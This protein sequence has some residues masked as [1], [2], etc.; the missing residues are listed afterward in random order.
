MS[1]VLYNTNSTFIQRYQRNSLRQ[2][3]NSSIGKDGTTTAAIASQIDDDPFVSK[4]IKDS[5]EYLQQLC[6]SCLPSS[7]HQRI[8]NL[9]VT[10]DLEIVALVA[11]IYKNFISHWYGV[12]IPT[13]DT[14]F[15][16]EI[17][18]I[19]ERLIS[20][21]REKSNL[22]TKLILLDEF[23]VLLSIHICALRSINTKQTM[24][25]GDIYKQYTKL[26]LYEEDTYPYIITALI[27]QSL[28]NTSLL[29]G[30]F[31]DALF[32]QLLLGRVFDSITEPY[33]VLRG[34]SKLCN[35]IIERNNTK[36]S[37]NT[38]SY[39][40][41]IKAKLSKIRK[42]VT[43]VSSYED[44][45]KDKNYDSL[46]NKYITHTFFVDL[47][48]LE[49]KKPLLYSTLKFIQN[50]CSRSNTINKIFNNTL[51]TLINKKVMNSTTVGSLTRLVRHTLFPNDNFMGPRTV[52]PTGVHF[53]EFK[54]DR[55]EELWQVCTIYKAS[56]VL[57]ITKDD[58]KTFI[59][60]I[61]ISKECNKLLMFRL[62]DCMLAHIIDNNKET[63]EISES[64]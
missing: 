46:M 1:T 35:K 49:I 40:S 62:I 42:M 10:P 64:Q 18:N 20:Y 15:A 54:N 30:T 36:I 41:M 2:N 39:W 12:K 32:N 8:R 43:Y 6:C 56:L 51:D 57:N 23:P 34:I 31:I 37:S 55:I 26:T 13:N 60:S 11:L 50:L 17:Y 21:L 25:S 38:V 52:I 24:G 22:N 33:Y 5:P 27:Q 14:Q 61:C 3:K 45:S 16:T 48:Q 28:D 59:D 9:K 58:V 63:H 4:H 53:E 7:L 47:L 29:Q 44:S 19:V